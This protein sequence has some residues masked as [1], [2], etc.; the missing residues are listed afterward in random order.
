[1]ARPPKHG[2]P[3]EAGARIRLPDEVLQ[4]W[5]AAAADIGLCLSDWLRDRVDGLDGGDPTG[6]VVQTR[7]PTPRRGTP[8]HRPFT[9]SDPAQVRE[10]AKIGNNLNQI[11]RWA[12]TYKGAGDAVEVIAHLRAIDAHLALHFPTAK[13]TGGQTEATDGSGPPVRRGRPKGAAK[14]PSTPNLPGAGQGDAP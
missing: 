11:A 14:A 10:L 8:R 12:N 2:Q 7:K 9:E 6:P 3:M 1:M 5:K 13:P 4:R